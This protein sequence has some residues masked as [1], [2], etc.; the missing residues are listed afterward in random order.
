MNPVFNQS[1][2]NNFSRYTFEDVNYQ[3]E[4]FSEEFELYAAAVKMAELAS[5]GSG[6]LNEFDHVA[7][8]LHQDGFDETYEL[9]ENWRLNAFRAEHE[10]K[11]NELVSSKYSNSFAG[12]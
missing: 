4:Y 8:D 12:S 1:P 10:K 7:K 2:L 6:E 5:K 11:I 9:V 3:V